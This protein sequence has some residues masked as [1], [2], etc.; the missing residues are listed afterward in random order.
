MASLGRP[1]ESRLHRSCPSK[2]ACSRRVRGSR[3]PHRWPPATRTAPRSRAT[4][5]RSPPARPRAAYSSGTSRPARRSALRCRAFAPLRDIDLH[6]GRNTRDRRLRGRPR[7][8]LGRPSHHAHPARLRSRR[9][10]ADPC[11]MGS[12]PARERIQPGVLRSSLPEPSSGIDDTGVSVRSDAC[13]PQPTRI[14]RN[15]D[16]LQ[17]PLPRTRQVRVRARPH[18]LA[19]RDRATAGTC[20]TAPANAASG[21]TQSRSMSL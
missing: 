20:A 15:R 2:R 10:P 7:N 1:R 8:P 21:T 18:E 13:D 16:R 5:A 17:P 3:S 9:P 19:D 11:G 14:A 6:T 4:A 12:V